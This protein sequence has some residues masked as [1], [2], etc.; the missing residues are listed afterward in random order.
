MT[1]REQREAARFA[2][3]LEAIAAANWNTATAFAL[4]VVAVASVLGWYG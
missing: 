4:W 3:E 1:T 2:R